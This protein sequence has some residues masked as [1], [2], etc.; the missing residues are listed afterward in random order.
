MENFDDIFAPKG[1]E[2]PEQ[3]P[4][5]EGKLSWV[6]KRK[7]ERQAMFDMVDAAMS[8]TEFL[9]LERCRM[10]PTQRRKAFIPRIKAF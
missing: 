4:A 1:E 10:F 3:Q 6:E 9:W 2:K 8:A 7:Q 5:Q